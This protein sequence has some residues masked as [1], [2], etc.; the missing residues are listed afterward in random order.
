LSG[1]GHARGEVKPQRHIAVGKVD[2]IGIEPGHPPRSRC[3]AQEFGGVKRDRIGVIVIKMR[4]C[5]RLNCHQFARIRDVGCNVSGGEIGGASKTSN[6][7]RRLHAHAPQGKI[8]K[9]GIKLRLRMTC[10]KTPTQSRFVGIVMS[11][12]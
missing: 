4:D 9:A 5:A 8:C 7:V 1:R 6:E 10:Q 2:T 3:G 11:N 12:C